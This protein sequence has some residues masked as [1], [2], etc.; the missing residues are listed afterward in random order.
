MQ[1]ELKGRGLTITQKFNSDKLKKK[2]KNGGRASIGNFL[3]LYMQIDVEV[4][5][6][7]LSFMPLPCDVYNL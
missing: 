1:G 6:F 5:F 7:S 2:K 3:L 4:T